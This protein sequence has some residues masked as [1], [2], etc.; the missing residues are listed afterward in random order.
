LESKEKSLPQSRQTKIKKLVSLACFL[1]ALALLTLYWL[2]LLLIFLPLTLLYSVLSR[3]RPNYAGITAQTGKGGG[4]DRDELKIRPPKTADRE[5]YFDRRF[6]VSK[7]EGCNTRN[8]KYR[9]SIYLD[10]LKVLE[11]SHQNLTVLDF[12]A[13][14]LRDSFEMAQRGHKVTS[15]DLERSIME[16]YCQFYPWQNVPHQPQLVAGSLQQ[17]AGRQYDI[18]TAF[19]VLEHLH[20]AK[21]VLNSFYSLLSD[22]GV[23]FITV[24]NKL[25]LLE[26][27]TRWAQIS[28]V[29]S[30]LRNKRLPGEDHVQFFTSMGWTAL[31]QEAG[32]K[33]KRHD[34]ALG[35]LVNDLYFALIKLPIGAFL[36]PGWQSVRNFMGLPE[37][38]RFWDAIFFPAGLME[39][40]NNLDEFL[41][42]VLKNR[43]GW[44]LF[45]LEKA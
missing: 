27:L 1:P 32:F 31:F 8:V 36:D 26:T 43:F 16:K 20:A 15:I 34:M 12:G 22:K 38:P 10:E 25:S 13:G 14:S 21:E 7:I 4:V 9:W 24:P 5:L 19:D 37:K 33:V 40:L 28:P 17:L 2:G 45:V 3:N 41:K 30:V 18:I 23:I 11:A 35:C 42:P 29:L 44:N 39:R 6:D